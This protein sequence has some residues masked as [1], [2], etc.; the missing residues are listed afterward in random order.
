MV[1]G[2]P[3]AGKTTFLRRIGLEALKGKQGRYN[4]R[5][6][7]VMLELRRYADGKMDLAAA[8]ADE[9]GICGFPEPR[10]ATLRLLTKGRLLLLLDGLDEMPGPYQNA[11]IDHI[12]DFVDRHDKNRFIASCRTAAYHSRFRRFTDVLMADFDDGQIQHFIARWF[13]S[14]RDLEAQTAQRC[15]EILND[16]GHAAAKELAQNPL[17]LT[18]LCLVFEDNQCFPANRAIL[19][20]DAL[21]VLLRRWAAEKHI[22][23]DPIYKDLTLPLEKAMLGRLAH[24]FFQ[25]GR[26]FFPR[27]EAAAALV[28][29][30]ADNLNAPRHL[31][32]DEVLTAIEI[33]QGIL[34]ARDHSGGVLSFSHL[35]FQEYLTA[36]HLAER[37]NWEGLVRQHLHEDQWREV[38]LLTAGQ[39]RPN[40]DGLLRAIARQCCAVASANPGLTALFRWA[41]AVT[42]ASSGA[43]SPVAKRV[44]AIG[45][46]LALPLALALTFDRARTLDLVAL[47]LDFAGNLALALALDII[48]IDR[49]STPPITRDPMHVRDLTQARAHARALDFLQA[50]ANQGIFNRT[51]EVSGF[52]SIE[53]KDGMESVHAQI[54]LAESCHRLEMSAEMQ[55]TIRVNAG[56]IFSCLR[57]YKLLLDCKTV[58]MSVSPGAWVEIEAGLF[59]VDEP[60]PLSLREG[61]SEL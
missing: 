54:Q 48:A 39:A 37:G 41:E 8:I 51:L 44:A 13:A 30:L 11:M 31:D 29:F 52:A 25:A 6:F 40:A 49:A 55:N 22:H 45:F 42:N 21:D 4:H 3:G 12:Q 18:L 7:P 60:E 56:V 16:T 35:T 46:A 53:Q 28:G 20:G 27:A 23:R 17:L 43:A 34:V 26:L 24:D 14:Q 32:G 59:L 61:T 1:L 19:Y 33:Q 57:A 36:Q 10:K 5:L 58:A 9:L 47:D 50:L 38:F 15:L 2:Q